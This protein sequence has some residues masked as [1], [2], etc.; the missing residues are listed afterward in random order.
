MNNSLV[1]K[2]YRGIVEFSAADNVFF[3]KLFGIND[4]VTFEGTSVKALEKSFREAVDD[5]LA[6]CAELGKE[7]E[8]IFKG[9]F[10]VRID[11]D[12]HRK[13]ALK[14]QTQSISLNELVENAIKKEVDELNP[15]AAERPVPRLKVASSV[16]K[17]STPKGRSK[18]VHKKG[19]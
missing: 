2:G 16:R 12:I 13:A 14:A 4:L 7:P 10:N 8:R 9:S 6:T 5:Y 19:R 15:E 3:G 11:P 17:A 1:Y 18:T